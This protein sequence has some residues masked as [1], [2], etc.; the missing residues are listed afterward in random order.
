M[1]A[2]LWCGSL[3]Q[4]PA[5]A[6]PKRTVNYRIDIH[7]VNIYIYFGFRGRSQR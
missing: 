2:P 5:E 4:H 7:C 6:I 1:M 3:P